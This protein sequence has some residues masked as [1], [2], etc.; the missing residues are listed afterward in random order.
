MIKPRNQVEG[1]IGKRLKR[2]TVERG[3]REF[4]KRWK[5]RRARARAL[6]DA[7]AAK[8][9]GANTTLQITKKIDYN[10]NYSLLGLN[11]N[12][13]YKSL[14]I[15]INNQYAPLIRISKQFI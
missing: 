11:Q 9:G 7:A 4:Y 15:I 10:N 14:L 6:P 12:E 13:A 8:P 1:G 3:E 2:K 5:R